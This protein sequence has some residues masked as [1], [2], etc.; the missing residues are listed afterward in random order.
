MTRPDNSRPAVVIGAG[1]YGLSVS[2]HLLGQGIPTRTFGDVMVSWRKHMPSGML[3]KS[4]ANA[5]S[6]STPQPGSTLHDFY[7]Y[8][9]VP[10]LREDQQ[11]PIEMFTRYGQ[12]FQQRQVANVETIPVSQLDQDNG[13]FH[14]KLDSGEELE[15]R[16]V[17]I[18]SG[19][20][21][22]P[23][24]P[25]GFARAVPG[26][27]S[28]DQ[29]VSHSSQLHDLT[30]FEGREVAIIGAGQSALEGAALMHEA[31]AKV[32]VLARERAH[33]GDPPKSEPTG[34][35]RL[36]PQPTSPLGPTWKLY[37]FSHA[38]GM[39]RYLP[40]QTRLSLARNVL[41]PLGAWWLRPRV[42]GQFPVHQRQR[43]LS[44]REDGGKAVLTVAGRSE[45]TVDHVV[46]ATGYRVDLDRI[47]YLSAGVRAR[48]RSVG[49]F[50]HLSPSFE[51]SVP[52]LYIV[53]MAAAETFGP[54]MRFVC[55]TSFAAPRVAASAR[56]R[57]EA[58]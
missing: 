43:V 50:P 58:R 24:M 34:L 2:A 3:L 47:S 48:L 20:I 44:I 33:F 15:T 35:R 19:L 39:Y 27:P 51:T 17:V 55:G 1:P 29:V 6:I 41:G 8:C 37:P 28:A 36:V 11:I 53:G 25:E 57:Q 40:D 56:R 45:L 38:A 26:G 46:A 23:Y 18:A 5:S 42:E 22:F 16:T 49:G 7:D 12:W 31:G 21:S 30:P 14:L 54:L 4:T 13:L 52:G 32:Q 9:G 10:R